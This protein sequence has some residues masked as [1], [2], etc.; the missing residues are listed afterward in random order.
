MNNGWDEHRLLV[1]A[2]FERHDESIKLLQKEAQKLRDQI[3]DQNWK[4]V[5]I[6][7]IGGIGGGGG[8]DVLK[9]F[10]SSLM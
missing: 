10:L 9:I 4:M 8:V 6:A 2:N 5:I 7:I 1:I 3:K